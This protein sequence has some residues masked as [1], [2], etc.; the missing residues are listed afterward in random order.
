V[1]TIFED[2]SMEEEFQESILKMNPYHNGEGSLSSY[3]SVLSN[4]QGVTILQLESVV[5]KKMFT[6]IFPIP[7]LKKIDIKRRKFLNDYNFN[8]YHSIS[9]SSLIF[10]IQNLS[11]YAQDIQG[12]VKPTKKCFFHVGQS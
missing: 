11:L 12:L 2:N 10:R 9:S 3:S 7:E 8:V 6:Y 4:P 1:E 5:D